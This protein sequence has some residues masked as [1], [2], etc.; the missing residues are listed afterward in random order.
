MTIS[1]QNL[2]LERKKSTAQFFP[3]NH[4]SVEFPVLHEYLGAELKKNME[5]AHWI[6][7]QTTLSGQTTC[8][9]A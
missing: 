5:D 2:F 3:G 8:H 1:G 6:L 7:S 9:T 4:P